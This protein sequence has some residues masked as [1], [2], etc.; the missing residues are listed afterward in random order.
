[1]WKTALPL[2]V[3]ITSVS[4]SACCSV[5]ND[6]SHT[7]SGPARRTRHRTSRAP[8]QLQ[9]VTKWAR[10]APGRHIT[11]SLVLRLSTAPTQSLSHRVSVRKRHLGLRESTQSVAPVKKRILRFSMIS[12][13]SVG[14]EHESRATTVP[15]VEASVIDYSTKR[16]PT[17]STLQVMSNPPATHNKNRAQNWALLIQECDGN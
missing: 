12:L 4:S 2:S 13:P 1:M 16:V 5:R 8:S 7:C 15:S 10:H 6:D 11:P 14:L 17:N 9:F 3:E